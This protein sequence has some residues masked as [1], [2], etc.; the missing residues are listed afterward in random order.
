MKN[1]S[2]D[3]GKM[4]FLLVW[5]AVSVA[6]CAGNSPK[7]DPVK[8]RAQLRWDSILSKDLDTA[9]SLYSPG[10]RSAHTR[11]D[12]EIDIRTKRVKWTSA[13]YIDQECDEDRCLVNFRVGFR[14]YQPVPGL[15][16]FDS[17]SI[18]QDT[19]VKTAGQ[20]WYVPPIKK[21]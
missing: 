20:W 2:A 1:W 7:S 3:K 18:V 9:Y 5:V 21:D 19:W 8:E 4:V 6:A 10:Y 13:E 14:L 15:K 11:V 17:E 16:V 12:Y